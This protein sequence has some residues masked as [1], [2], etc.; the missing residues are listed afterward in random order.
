ML[1]PS[2]SK[3]H[4]K[5]EEFLCNW[6]FS[7]VTDALVLYPCLAFGSDNTVSAIWTKQGNAEKLS[8]LTAP[9]RH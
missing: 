4:H 6:A 3:T 8:L 2:Y 1:S 5:E 9:Y 7:S